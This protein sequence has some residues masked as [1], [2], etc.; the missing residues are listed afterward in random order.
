MVELGFLIEPPLAGRVR[1]GLLVIEGVSVRESGPALAA[2]TDA[3]C[4][5]GRRTARSGD[6]L[7]HDRR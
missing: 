2:E 3:A 1:L 6:A 7:V 5:R 4:V